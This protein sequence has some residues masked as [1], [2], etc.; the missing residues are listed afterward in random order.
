MKNTD[1]LAIGFC[2][3][4]LMMPATLWAAKADGRKAKLFAKYDTNANGV[5]DEEE[6][7]AIQADYDKAREGDLKSFDKD[8]DGKFSPEEFEGMKAGAKGTKTGGKGK[9]ADGASK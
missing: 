4:G 7:K 9:K 2:V 6:R 1:T 3:L 8:H 5:L